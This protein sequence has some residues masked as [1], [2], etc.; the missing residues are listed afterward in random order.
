[1]AEVEL[2][3]TAAY[4]ALEEAESDDEVP[5][6]P[7][8][9]SPPAPLAAAS[10][11]DSSTEEECCRICMEGKESGRLISPC[12]CS[13]SVSLIHTRCLEQWLELRNGGPSNLE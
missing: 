8:P 2:E 6:L 5:A 13:G 7:A 10:R 1:M 12:E 11:R 3:S 9:A 4:A